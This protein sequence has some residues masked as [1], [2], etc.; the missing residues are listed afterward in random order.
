MIRSILAALRVAA[1][2]NAAF[3]TIGL[4]WGCW[5]AYVPAIK[6]GLGVSDGTFGLLLMGSACG[7]VSAMWIAPRVDRALGRRAMPTLAV[8]FVLAGLLPSFMG[9]PAA[10]LLSLFAVGLCSGLLDVSM[11]ARVSELEALHGRPLMNASHAMFAVGYAIS[12][13]VAGIEREAGLPPVAAQAVVA[14]AVILLLVPRMAQEPR[15]V[16]AP[17]SGRGRYP[18]GPILL[19]GSVVLTAFMTEAA[20]ESWSALHIERT[21]GG[22]AAEGALGPFMLGLTLAF[23][24]FSGQAVAERLREV[25][26]VV[27]AGTIASAG[28]LIAAWAPSPGV[29]YLGFGLFGLGVSVIGP[30]G[31]ALVGKMVAPHFRTE[32]ISRAAVIGFSGFFFAPVIMGLVS[33]GFG[34][35]LGLRAAFTLMAGLVAASVPLA[36]VLGRRSPEATPAAA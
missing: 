33:Q 26:V 29:A 30:M 21:L 34:P 9:A 12:A 23:G 15:H 35:E 16:G 11:N 32:A 13:L 20:V 5:A 36:L 2:P 14:A 19:C 4:F 7:L 10:F 28:A 22:R 6:A 8:L 17:P 25:T 24:R 31:L 3:V 18:W 27:I 1:A